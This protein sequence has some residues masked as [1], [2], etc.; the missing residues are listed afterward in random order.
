MDSIQDSGR[1]LSSAVRYVFIDC[2]SDRRCLV[3]FSFN[4]LLLPMYCVMLVINALVPVPTPVPSFPFPSS[5][6]LTVAFA[7]SK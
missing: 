1:D 3:A 6:L 5:F 4:L 7:A 2:R